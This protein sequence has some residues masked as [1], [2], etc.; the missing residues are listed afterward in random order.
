MSNDAWNFRDYEY[1]S[2]EQ[3]QEIFKSDELLLGAWEA[4][5]EFGGRP[6]TP[7]NDREVRASTTPDRAFQ[8]GLEAAIRGD[9]ASQA[10]VAQC[11]REGKGVAQDYVAAENWR[12]L[13]AHDAVSLA[14]L[15]ECYT[16]GYPM[17][18]ATAYYLC[19]AATYDVN[20]GSYSQIPDGVA[21]AWYDQ[22][23]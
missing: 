9:R 7:D 21:L 18:A 8:A 15:N 19:K 11:Y 6:G 17:N 4:D 20:N 2:D 22:S 23:W 13:A 10:R 14:L 16:K 3:V 1:L 5:T 12:R